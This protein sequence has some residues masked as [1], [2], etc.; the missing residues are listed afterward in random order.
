[1]LEQYYPEQATRSSDKS[2]IEELTEQYPNL[3]ISI[4]VHAEE[5]NPE[6]FT[7]KV[8]FIPS[9]YVDLKT[10]TVP[11]YDADGNPIIID[12]PSTNPTNPSL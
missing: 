6:E 1:M 10:E 2:I 11:G 3:Q 4:P 12:A 5:W 7:P 9:D 8:C